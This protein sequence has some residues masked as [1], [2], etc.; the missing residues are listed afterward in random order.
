MR[1]VLGSQTW[2]KQAKSRHHQLDDNKPAH[3]LKCVG[4]CLHG[5]PPLRKL[6]LCEGGAIRGNLA[7]SYL[8]NRVY[9]MYLLDVDAE[10]LIDDLQMVFSHV[11]GPTRPVSLGVSLHSASLASRQRWDKLQ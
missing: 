2:V 9:H 5:P 6:E 3:Q 4:Q 7:C 11:Q 1:L 8:D 10:I